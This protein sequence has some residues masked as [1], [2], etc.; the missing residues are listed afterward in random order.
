MVFLIKSVKPTTRV[1]AGCRFVVLLVRMLVLQVATRAPFSLPA[2]CSDHL[3]DRV[4]GHRDHHIVHDT[5]DTCALFF[6][7]RGSAVGPH[8]YARL[9][10]SCTKCHHTAPAFLVVDTHR[11]DA[12]CVRACVTPATLA[13]PNCRRHEPQC[14]CH[15][16]GVF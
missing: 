7:L 6:S 2:A 14:I 3:A 13:T 1:D 16:C 10:C 8:P 11:Q 12:R 15:A 5:S 4:H 9:R